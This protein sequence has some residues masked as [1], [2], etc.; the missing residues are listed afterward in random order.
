VTSTHLIGT[1]QT[2]IILDRDRRTEGQG[3]PLE[4]QPKPERGSVT[5]RPHVLIVTADQDLGSFLAEGLLFGGFW[6]S[7][8]ASAIQ[9]LEVLRLRGFDL[10]IVDDGIP[11][12]DAFELARRL[13][14]MSDAAD[15]RS[16]R[17]DAPL[18]L[19]SDRMSG[20]HDSIARDVGYAHV[21]YPPLDLEILVGTLHDIAE[22]WRKAHPEARI[23]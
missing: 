20:V 15:R 5:K 10:V 9:T 1:R 12:L 23:E 16:P 3:E 21:L 6:T 17:F 4:Q 11:G 7:V 18:I 13:H 14:D 2:P 8:I 22:K 19:I